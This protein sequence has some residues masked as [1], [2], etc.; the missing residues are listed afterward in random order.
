LGVNNPLYSLLKPANELK[1]ECIVVATVETL[2]ALVLLAKALF[3][4]LLHMFFNF[5]N[6]AQNHPVEHS[7]G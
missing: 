5:V 6:L 1:H 7:I 2:S 4:E 3:H